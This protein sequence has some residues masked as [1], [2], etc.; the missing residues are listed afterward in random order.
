M[1][2]L[3]VDA[4]GKPAACHVRESSGSSVLDDGTCAIAMARAFF[5]PAHDKVGRAVGGEYLMPVRW[6]LPTDQQ[7]PTID[8]DRTR[9]GPFTVET[10]ITVSPAGQITAC[11]VSPA[12]VDTP[13]QGPCAAYPVGKKIMPAMTRGKRPVGAQVFLRMQSETIYDD[14]LRAMW[15]FAASALMSR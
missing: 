1:V 13:E 7:M 6:T 4:S 10:R 14:W 9:G 2:M 12:E 8:V 11:Q 15:L 3:S 5:T